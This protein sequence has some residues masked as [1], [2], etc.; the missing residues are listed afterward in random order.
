M[1]TTTVGERHPPEERRRGRGRAQAFGHPHAPAR[2][3]LE[4]AVRHLVELQHDDGWWQGELQTNV[5]MDAEDL[6]MRQFL[7]VRTDE[8]TEQSARWVR[9][10]QREDGSWSTFYQG[11]ADP[12][13]T[14]E[15]YV[16]LRMAGDGPEEPHMRLAREIVLSHGGLGETRVFTRIWLALFGAWSWDDVPVLPPELV[17]LPASMPLNL[18]DFAC[19]ARQTIAPLTIL[20]ALRPRREL[21]FTIDELRVDGSRPV[22]PVRTPS[23]RA[24]HLLD[25]LLHGYER[26]PL[27]PTRTPA[28]QRTV[29]WILERQEADGSW[30]GIQPP[31]VYSL[32]AL[33]AYGYSIEDPVLAKGIA[34]WDRFTIIEDTPDGRLRRIEACQSPVWDTALSLVALAD[35]GVAAGHPAIEVAARWLCDEE[36]RVRGDWAVHRP[37]VPIGGWAFEFDNDLYPDIDDTAEVVMALECANVTAECGQSISRG[38]DWVIGMQSRDGGWGA[39]D[40]DNSRRL[41]YQLPF[42]DFGA[43]NDPPS[44]DVTAH[45]VEM[46]ARHGAGAEAVQAGVRWMLEHQEA[47][48]SWFGRWGA[49]YVYGTGAVVPALIS[50]GV[51]PDSR[52]VQRA[53]EWLYAHQN[54]DGGWGEDLRSYTDDSWIGRGESTPSQTGW[55]LLALHAAGVVDEEPARRG[56]GW[57]VRAQRPDGSWDEPQFTGTGFPGDFFIN[58]HL[59]RLV[60]PISALGRCLGRSRR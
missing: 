55:A 41:A 13:V 44:A 35:A 26:L 3:A 54:A 57:L 18:Y 12:S 10:Q 22:T 48:G 36:I 43:V 38:I 53:V 21:G 2:R 14:A 27:R 7:G 60:F 15:A 50:A 19:W 25:S 46:L 5:T 42:F 1:S 9:S 6:L 52:C 49:N 16:A 8:Q 30:G 33:H 34:G 45:V 24:F 23:A 31:W 29:K 17:F 28:L 39:F 40:A 56:I 59:Y 37:D 47:D 4:R 58:Y 51:P 20:A 32:M 11:P